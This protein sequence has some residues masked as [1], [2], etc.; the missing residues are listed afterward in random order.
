LPDAQK[1]ARPPRFTGETVLV[2]PAREEPVG[3]ARIAREEPLQILGGD[4]AREVAGPRV[5]P[6]RAG[7]RLGSSGHKVRSSQ[8][9][10]R[11]LRTRRGRT[12][13]PRASASLSR[14][15]AHA[16]CH[17]RRWGRRCPAQ[18]PRAR[19][20]CLTGASLWIPR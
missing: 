8:S 17:A 10:V 1:L 2:E 6:V 9:L 20:A 4:V 11:R 19:T 3:L 14:S 18:T 15:C 16:P 13:D 5:E 7:S 12:A